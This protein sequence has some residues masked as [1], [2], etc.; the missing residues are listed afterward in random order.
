MGFLV[1]LLIIIFTGVLF[2]K[3]VFGE[4]GSNIG[5]VLFAPS[6]ANK[7]CWSAD[8]LALLTARMVFEGIL[9]ERNS[10]NVNDEQ[11]INDVIEYF[12]LILEVVRKNTTG[13]IKHIMLMA[14]TDTLGGYMKHFFLPLAKYAYYAGNVNYNNVIRVHQL[15]DELKNYLRT[16]GAG[17]SKAPQDLG[18]AIVA[19]PIQMQMQQITDRCKGLIYREIGNTKRSSGPKTLQIAMPYFDSKTRPSAIAIPFKTYSLRNVESKGAAY[20]LVKFYIASTKCLT[21]KDV[22]PISIQEFNTNLFSFIMSKVAPHFCDERF[23]AAFGGVLR[24]VETMKAEGF[25]KNGKVIGSYN[26]MPE[27]EEKEPDMNGQGLEEEDFGEK[28]MVTYS[29]KNPKITQDLQVK[30]SK[31]NLI[32]LAALATIIIWFVLGACFVCCRIRSARMKKDEQVKLLEDGRSKTP[33]T[34]T[35]KTKCLSSMSSKTKCSTMSGK[36][37]SC[38]RETCANFSS[39]T[40]TGHGDSS[41]TSKTSASTPKS[42]TRSSADSDGNKTSGTNTPKGDEPITVQT[43]QYYPA[44]FACHSSMSGKYKAGSSSEDFSSKSTIKKPFVFGYDF[45][46][47]SE[48]SSP[49]G[50]IIS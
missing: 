16:N 44:S 24:I 31:S 43:A 50:K 32:M 25:I 5:T 9:P 8:T 1:K 22:N 29:D 12:R 20:V 49:R 26:I 3:A 19:Q 45:Q 18:R 15:Y 41:V 47:T 30:K 14:L 4:K 28:S 36:T 39:S 33:S 10:L 27:V 11:I 42:G 37:L 38:N 48:E 21:S 40:M 17:W 6:D 13:K 7:D 46:T 35:S 23:Y 34:A 2:Y